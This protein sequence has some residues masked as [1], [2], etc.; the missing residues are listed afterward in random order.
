MDSSAQS[1]PRGNHNNKE[2]GSKGLTLIE[3]IVVVVIVVTM[4]TVTYGL[5]TT[6]QFRTDSR[7]SID[8]LLSQIKKQRIKAMLGASYE[9][10]ASFGTAVKFSAGT[11]TYTLYTCPSLDQSCLYDAAN[12]T[13]VQEQMERDIIIKQTAF[14]NDTIIFTAKSGDTYG[15]LEEGEES[16]LISNIADGSE[17]LLAFSRSGGVS[18]TKT[19]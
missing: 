18:V 14:A 13:S 15:G 8:T 17:Y 19:K 7:T 9:G 10:G 2:G 11:S 16:V 3:V 6:L 12:T 4:S 1:T 5:M